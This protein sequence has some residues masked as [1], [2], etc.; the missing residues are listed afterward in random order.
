[1]SAPD[2][3]RR[4]A[5]LY[6]ALPYPARDPRDEARRL[7]VGTPSHRREIDHFLFAGRRDWRQPFRVLVA[8]G[9]TGD[10]TVMIAQQMADLGCPAAITHLEP[11]EAARKVAA[12]RLERRGLTM[13]S[14]DPRPIEALDPARDGPFD[15]VDCCGVLHHLADPAAALRRLAAV[16]APTGGI[17]AMVYGRLGRS[18]VYEM[19][20]C[21]AELTGDLDVVRATDLARRL[22][23]D[24]P[25]TA[26]LARNPVVRD[27]VDG[28]A[29]G[30]ADLLLHPRDRAF[31]AAEVAALIA[32]AGLRLIG[33]LPPAQYDPDSYVRH[34]EAR[35]RLAALDPIGRAVWAERFAGN[36]AR[37][38]FYAVRADNPVTPPTLDDPAV[39][40]A[41]RDGDPAAVADAIGTSG[42]IS[43]N[44]DGLSLSLPVPRQAGTVV[45][46]LDDRR[47]L[48]L[49]TDELVATAVLR[50][51]AA[52]MA[53]VRDTL[54]PLIAMNL[55]TLRL[56]VP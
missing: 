13:V 43:I 24:L 1:L 32:G 56:P 18:G 55:V 41:L 52:A 44:L 6:E 19:Q 35:R 23:A 26:P 45:R 34:P 20:A 21:L 29:A 33:F 37:H 27:H 42:H 11:S 10:G 47:N 9:G 46:R 25:P 39:V 17:G 7:L 54:R 2:A 38:A 40:P 8:G 4:V 30:I 3:D 22:L 16:L 49:I 48:K 5:A 53:A 31:D 28:G 51:P 36:L 14:I 15:H 12:A 50:D